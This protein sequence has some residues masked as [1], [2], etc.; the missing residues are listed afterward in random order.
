[1]VSSSSRI[2][3]VSV[4]SLGFL[5]AGC[6]SG[7]NANNAT[8]PAVVPGGCAAGSIYSTQYGCLNQGTCSAGMALYQGTCISLGNSAL[9]SCQPVTGQPPLYSAGQQYGCLPQGNCPVGQASYI[10]N[11]S[12][13]CVPAQ[14]LADRYSTDQWDGDD[15][16][17]SGRRLRTD[18]FPGSA[19]AIR[20]ER[21]RHR[22]Q[23]GGVGYRVYYR[24]RF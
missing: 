5:L 22:L 10:Y 4:L 11:N 13:Q 23:R 1:M 9:T 12:V 18:C 20:R 21:R 8:P 16:Y 19:R 3:T 24:R 2:F 14:S 17:R 15:D 7:N 6:G